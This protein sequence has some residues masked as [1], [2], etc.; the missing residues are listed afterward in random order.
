SESFEVLLIAEK[1]QE[2]PMVNR[3]F[4]LMNQTQLHQ[5][6]D[7]GEAISLGFGKALY[8]VKQIYRQLSALLTGKLS[9]KNMSGPI[10]IAGTAYPAAD[11]D[12][13]VLILFLGIISVN[14]AVVNFLPIPILD[15]GHMVFLI[16]EWVRG[17]PA[18]QAIFAI[19]NYTGLFVIA[20]LMLFVI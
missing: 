2:W 1:D 12:F 17:K 11:T 3:G 15:G 10:G 19:A 4:R 16:Y 8:Y 7:L 5:A 14:L 6:K 13:Y 9:W 20:S 18:S